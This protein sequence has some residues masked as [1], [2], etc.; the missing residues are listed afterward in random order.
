[1]KKISLL[2]PVYNSERTLRKCLTTIFSSSYRNF[3]LVIINDGSCDSS[4]DIIESFN[5]HRINYYEKSNSGLIDSLNFGVKNCSSEI[6][7]RIDSDDYI[8]HKK[9]ELQLRELKSSNSVLI[10][11]NAYVVD[12]GDKIIGDTN[13]PLKHSEIV[14]SMIKF[15]P[16]IIHPS[17]MV[18]KEVL[19]KVN[20]FDEKYSH[21]EDYD[22]FLRI[23]RLGKISNISN[24]LM[25]LR[26]ST[27]NISHKNANEQI[28]NSFIS[29]ENYLINS[30]FDKTTD[31]NFQ[32]L[33]QKI[34]HN[35]FK[36]FYISIHTKIVFLEFN[37]PHQNTYF[38]L[39]TLK[40][41]RRIFILFL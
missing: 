24:K 25:Y 30:D 17:I 40:I 32:M 36:S 8:N 23:S 41:L 26:K 1:M 20:Y 2:L 28:V 27:N 35:F 29:R 21:A 31:E 15:R 34:N 38:K 37:Q 12:E 16:S 6:I 18:Y 33:S 4:K 5:D 9:I 13:L 19:G 11:T 39:I 3:E 7:M 22:L 10:G 14:K